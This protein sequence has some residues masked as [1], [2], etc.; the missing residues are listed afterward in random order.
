M[1]PD[2]W[3]R[4]EEIFHTAISLS[5]EQRP[6]YL[7]QA[8]SQDTSLRAEVESL[9]AAFE[10]QPELMARPV[11]D[12]GLQALS[13]KAEEATLTGQQIGSYEVLEL[14]GRGGMGDVY[15]AVDVKLNRKVALKFL[16][17]R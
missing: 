11:F 15:L 12:L 17:S 6:A 10:G 9:I 16:S 14:L 13:G 2:D 3:Q 8:C 7:A 5:A 4:V 1:N